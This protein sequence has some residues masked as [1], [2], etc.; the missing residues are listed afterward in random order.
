MRRRADV[1][2][3]LLFFL[4]VITLYP[5]ALSPRP[6]VLRIIGPGVL[7]ISALLATLMSLG[8][9]FR[10]DLEDGTLEQLVLQPV[11]LPW[12]MLAKIL[13]HW[14]VTGVPLVLLAP[15]AGITYH[16]PAA[17]T[18]ALVISLLLGTPVLSLIGAIGAALTAGL[19]HAGALLALLVTP[20]MVP[21][22][23]IGARAT[24]MA[25]GGDDV[26]GIFYLLGALLALAL[27][28]APLAAAAAIRI[29]LD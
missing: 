7:W 27:P 8:A 18:W 20:L 2:S 15:V 6:E 9:L 23:M 5:L 12:L 21:V 16:L 14:L 1:A 28:L 29:S 22:L 13:A 24:D 26:T 19:R 4:I 3:P 10:A 17:G 11:P 25:A